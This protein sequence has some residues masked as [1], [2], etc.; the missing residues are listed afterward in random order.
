MADE[1]GSDWTMPELTR[2]VIAL[3]QAVNALRQTIDDLE[4]KFVLRAVHDVELANVRQV[5]RDHGHVLDRLEQTDIPAIHARINRVRESAV[6]KA[7][8]WQVV[9]LVLGIATIGVALL[10]IYHGGS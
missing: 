7:T 6:S 3:T 1:R 4:E 10:A 2:S 8:V 5:Q 9:G